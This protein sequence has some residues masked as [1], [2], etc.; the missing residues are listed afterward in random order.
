M[1]AL[2]Y[3]P[4]HGGSALL[5]LAL[6]V[7][8]VAQA[9]PI[10][11][12]GSSSRSWNTAANWTPAQV[13]TLADDVTFPQN[14]TRFNPRVN[15]ATSAVTRT[16]DFPTGANAYAL[17][18]AG[19]NTLTVAG[20]GGSGFTVATTTVVTSSCP[21]TLTN[22]QV[23][24][25]GTLTFTGALTA[26][27]LTKT[28]AGTLNIN[29]NSAAVGSIA[30]NAGTLLVGNTLTGT[31]A[32]AA[33]GT[34]LGGAGTISGTVTIASGAA[35]DPGTAAG[36]GNLAT[37]PLIMNAG[38]TLAINF[39]N[40]ATF[41]SVNVTGTATVAGT[42]NLSGNTPNDGSYALVT[43]SGTMTNGGV[44][45]G[46]IPGGKAFGIRVTGN[47][48]FLDVAT[49][50][51]RIDTTATASSSCTG[52]LTWSHTVSGN[53]R[54]LVVGVSTSSTAGVSPT[55]VTYG[56]TA[57]TLQQSDNAGS[58]RVFWY[59]LLAPALGTA[60]VVVALPVTAACGVVGG[61]MS[62]T[63][64]NQATPIGNS[65]TTTGTNTTATASVT[66]TQGD[67]AVG[68]LAATNAAT[69]TPVAPATLRY[70]VL[71]SPVIG[72]AE[73]VDNRTNGNTTP[74]VAFTLPGTTTLWSL[75]VVA[76]NAVAPTGDASARAMVRATNRGT[77]VSWRA[78]PGLDV[79]GYRVWR[80]AG[81]QRTL[82]TPSLVAGP[83]MQSRA[84]ALAG[85]SYDWED[86]RPI[87]GARYW[88]ESLHTSGKTTW[89][90]ATAVPGKVAA[91]A[92]SAPVL[93]PPSFV[94]A[95]SAVTR[96]GTRQAALVV[97]TA[98]ALATQQSLA[99]GAAVKLAVRAEGVYRVPAESLFAA[100]ISPGASPAALQLF[101][102]GRQV[103]MDVHAAD[104]AH[105]QAGDSVEF[106]GLGMDT[107]YTDTAV[108]WLVSGQGPAQS[109]TTLGG[110]A[111]GATGAT[112]L[113]TREL[114]E[115]LVWYGAFQNGDAEKFFG[116]P[117]FG[118]QLTT[119]TFAVDALDPLAD[120]ASVEV[121]LAGV[122]DVPHVVTVSVNGLAVGSITFDGLTAGAASLA[123]PPGA[124]VGGDTQVSLT[125][126]GPDDL[127]LENYVRLV[128]PRRTA[129]GSGA[130]VFSLPGGTTA[131]LQGFAAA[132]TRVLDV[133]D[134]GA[135]VRL[136][137]VDDGTGVASVLVSGTGPRRLLA[138]LPED[139]VQPAAVSA[140]TPS[141]L[142]SAIGAHLLVVGPPDLLA[143]VAPLV[144]QRQAEGMSVM[145]IDIE[146]VLDEYGFGAK[147]AQ[148]LHDFLQAAAT[149]WKVR[150]YFVL[151][152]GLGTYDPR[153][154]LGLGGD[155]VSSGV[156]Q[157][158]WFETA[159]DQWFIGFPGAGPLA[160]GRLPVRSAAEAAPLVAK[161]LGRQPAGP[162]ASVLLVAD[163]VGTSDFP[164]HLQEV[165]SKLPS[166][167]L[168]WILRGTDSDDALHEQ[169]LAQVRQGP[170]V[171]DYAGHASETFWSGDIH[172]VADA[173]LLAGTGKT[174]LFVHA[175][176]DTGFFQD[177]RR[178]S[179]AV[180][181][182]LASD[183]GAWGAWAFTGQSLPSDHPAL[184]AAL[185]DALLNR[186]QTLGEA[187]RAA[188][189]VADDP[190]T[191][192]TFVLLGDPSA[193]LTPAK[194]PAL[195]TPPPPTGAS[196][197]STTAGPA[198]LLPLLLAAAWLLLRR[199]TT[200]K[201]PKTFRR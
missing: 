167:K 49:E 90:A 76:L 97:P 80:E 158:P 92:A 136:S 169:F 177:P 109:L 74:A 141:A 20:N 166:A 62:F 134:P 180:A 196:G 71:Q 56:G 186:G 59:G 31:S 160:I 119:H 93:G 128:Y 108:Y 42:V 140:N 103:P 30:L 165:A 47:S 133:T 51:I 15:G 55:S 53:D 198:G 148:A 4:R 39:S 130:M 115:R 29:A 100:G 132:S 171:V 179:L 73:T 127:T 145:T 183:G 45:L 1:S 153:D 2:T 120:G 185:V 172:E 144:A 174:S 64:V 33:S 152:A 26:T 137:V 5:L 22:G 146:D 38:S 199:P 118:P 190:I 107:R 27:T 170:A 178:Q 10:S 13:P 191:Q 114:R 50:P 77:V 102:D 58:N 87:A 86:L 82:L 98:D 173:A 112:Y 99:G 117:V 41:T 111:P 89:D 193:R 189:A 123:I 79:V 124:V 66:L 54:Y 78:G 43:S 182:L 19:T 7:A 194:S 113:E 6:L 48:L 110:P 37:G 121:A 70:S 142:S 195:T 157:T 164:G 131:S 61:S 154:Y 188:L 184:N 81:G 44:T 162:D 11:W 143:A 175:T 138:Y 46:T 21:T 181:M 105:L 147:S 126:S 60:N 106:Y 75:S 83:V 135:P 63:G 161:I 192:Q 197:C 8:P 28:G 3:R 32:T 57:L 36:T 159:S 68:V 35:L 65:T 200:A 95:P 24:V 67:R 23:S 201:V 88:L 91:P 34:T 125:S 94:A 96:G 168:Q 122:T 14:A 151:L 17:S 116:E 155:R 149:Q 156:V 40:G 9:V 176:C 12:D 104:G 150:P 163:A 72:A 52:N 18:C 25:D 69:A 85:R 16:V 139:T 84:S 129:R 101:R 187:T